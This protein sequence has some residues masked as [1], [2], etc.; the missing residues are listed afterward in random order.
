MLD[1][2]DLLSGGA[3]VRVVKVFVVDTG[4]GKARDF[5][6]GP[7]FLASFFPV[8]HKYRRSVHD[9]KLLFCY[10]FRASFVTLLGSHTRASM[11]FH[12]KRL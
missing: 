6:A 4:S 2:P 1:G 5:G 8:L 12:L 3:R 10:V 7:A 9:L 11:D